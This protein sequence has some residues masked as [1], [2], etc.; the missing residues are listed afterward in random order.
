MVNRTTA[1]L[2]FSAEHPE[3]KEAQVQ[4]IAERPFRSESIQ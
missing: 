3:T 1:Y 2:N 4:T